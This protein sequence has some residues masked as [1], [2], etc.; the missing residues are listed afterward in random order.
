[1]KSFRAKV[2]A[3]SDLSL[4]MRAESSP[5]TMLLSQ[6]MRDRPPATLTFI[7]KLFLF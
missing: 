7:E 3:L 4:N 5:A 6:R 1:M 2:D